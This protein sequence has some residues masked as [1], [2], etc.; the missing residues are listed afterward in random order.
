MRSK[1][2]HISNPLKRKAA[3]SAE[4]AISLVGSPT[5]HV[6]YEIETTVK[7]TDKREG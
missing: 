1:V 2:S 4:K 5:K 7:E 6:Y 3:A